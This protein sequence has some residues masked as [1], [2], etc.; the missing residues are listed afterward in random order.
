RFITRARN[1]KHV[2]DDN[3]KKRERL[4]WKRIRQ[5]RIVSSLKISLVLTQDSEAW[6]IIG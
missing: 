6:K 5:N 4:R 2:Y 1:D 3:T